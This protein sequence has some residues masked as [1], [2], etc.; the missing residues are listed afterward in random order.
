MC[1]GKCLQWTVFYQPSVVFQFYSDDLQISLQ[2]EA[3]DLYPLLIACVNITIT[4]RRKHTVGARPINS[5][6][7]VRFNI[8]DDQD[9]VELRVDQKMK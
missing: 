6:L 4:F 1:T 5:Y 8:Q 7:L 9:M 2:A 3:I